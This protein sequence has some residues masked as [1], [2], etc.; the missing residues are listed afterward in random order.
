MWERENR[1]V[2][3]VIIGVA[4]LV[5]LVLAII[6]AVHPQKWQLSLELAKAL[7]QL[8]TV[9][10]V[11]AII[12]LVLERSRDERD[13]R[14]RQDDIVRE[15]RKTA[16]DSYS[17]IKRAR[18]LLQARTTLGRGVISVNAYDQFIAV[19]DEAQL[20]FETRKGD[21]IADLD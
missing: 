20:D 3:I 7:L 12:S 8:L 11:G 2:I 5:A 6:W 13:R 14:Q 18:R 1:K 21:A 4:M 9:I 16:H 15:V 10:M 17:K 19:I